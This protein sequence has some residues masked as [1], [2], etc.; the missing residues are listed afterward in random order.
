RRLEIDHQLELGRLLDR[1]VRGLRALEDAASVGAQLTI[2]VLEAGAVTHQAT[3]V[4]KITA[5]VDFGDRVLCRKRNKS[6][7][8]VVEER[9]GSNDHHI[10]ASLEILRENCIEFI[11]TGGSQCLQL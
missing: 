3:R 4:D 10:C 11:L 5:L 9:V 8:A 2:R 6:V 1:Q 7:A